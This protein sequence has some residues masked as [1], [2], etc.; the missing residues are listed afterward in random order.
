MIVYTDGG[1]KGNPGQAAIG[2]ILVKDDQIIKEYGEYIGISTNNQAE[3]KAIIKA[4]ELCKALKEKKIICYSDS[5]LLINQLNGLYKIKN[6][7]LFKLILKIKKLEINFQEVRYNF[8]PRE[9]PYIKKAHLL[10]H[11]YLDE[12]LIPQG[13]H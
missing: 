6:K 2:I 12:H 11:K 7:D 1:S 13:K 5:I 8:V 4:L 10:L 3:Y 9:N